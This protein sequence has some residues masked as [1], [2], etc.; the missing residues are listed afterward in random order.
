MHPTS[1][2]LFHKR[3]QTQP[4]TFGIQPHHSLTEPV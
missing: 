4:R 2:H 3:F 1:N